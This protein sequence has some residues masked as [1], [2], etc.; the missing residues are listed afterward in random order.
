MIVRSLTEAD[1]NPYAERGFKRGNDEKPVVAKFLC[2]YSLN[3]GILFSSLCDIIQAM[4]WLVLIF[5]DG[6]S[7]QWPFHLI[8]C[9][10]SVGRFFF[11]WRFNRQDTEHSR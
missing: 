6:G 9:L 4:V 8:Y 2:C 10:L 1:N 11:F 7:V 5:A 3:V